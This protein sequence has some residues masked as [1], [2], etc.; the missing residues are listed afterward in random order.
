MQFTEYEEQI[1]KLPDW[2]KGWILAN[3]D[4]KCQKDFTTNPPEMVYCF[5]KIRK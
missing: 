1:A 5:N 2:Y 3:N 4:N